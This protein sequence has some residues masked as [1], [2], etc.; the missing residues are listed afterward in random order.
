MNHYRRIIRQI[1]LC[2]VFTALAGT[3]FP[4]W[5]AKLQWTKLYSGPTTYNSTDAGRFVCASPDGNI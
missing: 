5:V 2:L 4:R 1:S 3:V